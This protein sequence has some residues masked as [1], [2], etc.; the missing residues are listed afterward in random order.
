MKKV[1]LIVT[2]I[3]IFYSSFAG[4]IQAIQNNGGWTSNSSWD[5]NR[6]PTDGDTITIPA[7]I[8]IIIS[9]NLNFPANTMRIIVYGTLK[10]SGGGAKLDISSL[11]SI[12][13]EPGGLLTSTGSPSQTI[14]I[15]SQVVFTGIDLPVVGPQMANNTTGNGFVP[16]VILPVK[17]LSFSIS[18]ASS[19]VLVQWSTAEEVNA[20]RYDIE[21]SMDGV[22]WIIAGTVSAAGNSTSTRYYNYS[23]HYSITKKVY[24][25]IKEIDLSGQY[26]YTAIKELQNDTNG[27]YD[28]K[29][30]SSAQS[31][32]VI[33]FSTQINDQVTIRIIS[34]SGQI[35]FE[36][37]VS[38]PMGQYQMNISKTGPYII[39][40][41]NQSNLNITKKLML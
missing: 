3:L 24:Y 27:N 5:L 10:F 33:E 21:R 14:N 39:Q 4:S 7:G 26:S 2:F 12:V 8:T 22:N 41:S 37:N 6:N 38:R 15:G 19:V 28:I 9:S 35:V 17:F 40:V 36:K 31:M 11:S 32:A 30:Y 13:V 23:D 20:L 18:Y 1:N 16:F 25:R 34:F 29:I